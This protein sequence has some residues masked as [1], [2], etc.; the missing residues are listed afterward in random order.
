MVTIYDP[1]PVI[2][3]DAIIF[4]VSF[5]CRGPP[6][7]L[8]ST[9]LSAV[10]Q[11]TLGPP[12]LFLTGTMQLKTGSATVPVAPVGVPPTGPWRIHRPPNGLSIS[13]GDVFGGTPKTAGGT[14]RAPNRIASFRLKSPPTSR[15]TPTAFHSHASHPHSASNPKLRHSASRSTRRVAHSGTEI[16]RSGNSASHSRNN[17][18]DSGHSERHS[19]NKMRD[20]GGKFRIASCSLSQFWKNCSEGGRLQPQRGCSTQPRVGAKRLPWE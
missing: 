12:Q 10:P 19:G 3:L 16:L 6:A 7:G 11:L 4:R 18:C 8:V 14:P 20:S 2:P 15:R 13:G 5:F 1:G 9:T 17:D